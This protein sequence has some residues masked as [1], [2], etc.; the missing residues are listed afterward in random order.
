MLMYIFYDIN[1]LWTYYILK[2][3]RDYWPF[4]L[5]VHKYILILLKSVTL[6]VTKEEVKKS[7]VYTPPLF[8]FF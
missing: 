8:F 3:K 6:K 5:M 1:A 4:L 2:N 7:K